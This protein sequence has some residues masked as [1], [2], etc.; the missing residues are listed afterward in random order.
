M[1]FYDILIASFVL[2]VIGC[3]MVIK[4]KN[5]ISDL[6][7]RKTF[8]QASGVFIFSAVTQLFIIVMLAVAYKAFKIQ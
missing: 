8:T 6:N 2:Q 3:Y 1:P 5:K 4:N 7:L